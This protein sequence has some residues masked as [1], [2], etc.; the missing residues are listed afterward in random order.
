[1]K[2][3]VDYEINNNLSFKNSNDKLFYTPEFSDTVY[4]IIGNPINICPKVVVHYPAADINSM[5]KKKHSENIESFIKLTNTAQYYSFQGE[6]ICNDDLI[7]YLTIYKNGP[8]GY[9]Y[10]E[11]TNKIIGGN[12]VSKLFP[13]DTAQLD[14]YK[15]P[16][17]IFNDHFVSVLTYSDFANS[18]RLSSA[19]LS[20]IKKGIKPSDNPVLVF[21]KL[22][23]F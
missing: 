2:A 20:A 16:F 10:S 22:K 8:T 9:F 23:D 13:T 14:G 7:Y 4:Q 11:K 17:T 1:M 3:H 15:Y 21:Y 19:K 12:L 6:L 18:K 5:L